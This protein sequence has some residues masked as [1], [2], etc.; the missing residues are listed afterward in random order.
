[1]L[2]PESFEQKKDYLMRDSLL[3]RISKVFKK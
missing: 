2:D 3:A 1:M